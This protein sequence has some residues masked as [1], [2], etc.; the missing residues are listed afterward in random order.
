VRLRAALLGVAGALLLVAGL[1]EVSGTA[2][3]NPLVAPAEAASEDIAESTAAVYISLRIINS[4]LSVAQEI[5]LGASVGA[6][7]GVQ[8]LKV[9]EPVDDTVERVASVVFAIAA[10]AAIAWVGLGPV[11][12]IG[13]VILGAGLLGRCGC[14]SLPRA[15][16][17]APASRRAVALGAA[18]GLVLPLVFAFGVAMGQWLTQPRWDDAMATLDAVTA[19]AATLIGVGDVEEIVND[20]GEDGGGFLGALGQRLS[21]A[22]SAVG[23]AADAVERY[24]EAM[25]VFL[26]RADDLFAASLTLIAIFA[27]RILVL[28]AL[29]LWGAMTI[30][31]QSLAT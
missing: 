28:P 30:L 14:E 12:G 4:A 23:D 11:A 16:P 22:G 8:P 18:L 20:P 15:A 26:A 1:L 27:L 21:L 3:V 10:G 17:F 7:I 9:L 6:Q 24:T 2:R 29:L 19:E 31:R 25:G 5:E 13:L